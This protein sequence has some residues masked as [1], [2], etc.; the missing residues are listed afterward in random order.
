M[1]NLFK[2][3]YN[4]GKEEYSISELLK[5]IEDDGW[6]EIE[7]YPG[8]LEKLAR[9]ICINLK[10]E[11]VSQN[12]KKLIPKNRN[13]VQNFSLS[14]AYGLN[15]FPLHTDGAEYLIPPRFLFLRALVDS[16]TATTLVD[17][18]SI[19]DYLVNYN[20]SWIVKTKNG[21]IETKLIEKI[22]KYECY[23]FRFNRLS[24]KCISGNRSEICAKID[25][26]PVKCIDWTK[27]KTL[28]VDNW[29]VLHGRKAVMEYNASKRIL[30]R[31]LVFIKP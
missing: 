19:M 7:Y 21:V 16:P 29:R 15:E 23:Y 25:A 14:S 17:G 10:L 9:E 11:I 28:I 6:A 4:W 12:N 8:D 30:E 3:I 18:K 5:K 31:L 27:Y 26:L 24:M 13:Q 2:K 22:D 1:I 20:S